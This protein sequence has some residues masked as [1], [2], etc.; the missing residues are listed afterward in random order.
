MA[1][2]DRLWSDEGYADKDVEL[3]AL[4]VRFELCYR[5]PDTDEETW[6]VTQHLSPSKP[7]ELSEW[8]QPGDLVLKY[9]YEFLPRGLVSRLI[10]R[11]HRFVRRPDLCWSIGALFEHGETQVLVDTTARAN[12]IVLRGRGPEKQALLSVIASDL[13]ALNS[14]FPGLKDRVGKWVPCICP[15]CVSLQEPATFEYKVLVDRKNRGKLTIECPNPPDYADVS[16]LKLIDG[17]NL[18]QWLVRSSAGG[19]R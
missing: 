12:E 5:L 4:M 16:V 7:M 15:T 18:E 1:A 2:C 13:E 8:A 6:L 17:M 10:V 9:C 3:R 19:C 14:T 11:V